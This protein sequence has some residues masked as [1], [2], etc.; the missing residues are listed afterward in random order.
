M[1]ARKCSIS[2]QN[3]DR[4]EI[5]APITSDKNDTLKV[6]TYCRFSPTMP[7]CVMCGTRRAT[8]GVQI[9]KQAT[10]KWIDIGDLM[11]SLGIN[12][13][14]IPDDVWE[15]FVKEIIAKPIKKYLATNVGYVDVNS[16]Q[17]KL[18]SDAFKTKNITVAVVTDEK[19]VR[20]IVTA[21]SWLGVNIR[22]FSWTE[23]EKAIDYLAVVQPQKQRTLEA[24]KQLRKDCAAPALSKP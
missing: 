12:E 24:I 2:V 5:C 13:G 23:L 14:P 4:D 9:M 3:V 1:Q 7:P 20:G 10:H 15:R 17:R 18:I 6:L 11:V 22:S 21:V 8:K 16:V 19:I